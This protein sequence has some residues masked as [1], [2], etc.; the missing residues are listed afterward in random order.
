[1]FCSAQNRNSKNGEEQ[2][3]TIMLLILQMGI[4]LQGSEE[5]TKDDMMAWSDFTDLTSFFLTQRHKGSGH[6]LQIIQL[7]INQ[8]CCHDHVQLHFSFHLTSSFPVT[9]QILLLLAVKTRDSLHKQQRKVYSPQYLNKSR[10]NALLGTAW[11][12]SW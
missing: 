5:A 2:G 4:H 8:R 7:I 3:K 11:W 9:E 10:L 6:I 12:T 1:M